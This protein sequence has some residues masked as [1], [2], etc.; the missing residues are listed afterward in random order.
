MLCSPD[1]IFQSY[2]QQ[3]L[4]SQL[5]ISCIYK[6]P[7]HVP[8][9]DGFDSEENDDESIYQYDYDGNSYQY[10]EHEY[11][12]NSEESEP[13]SDSTI[14]TMKETVP[15][16]SRMAPGTRSSSYKDEGYATYKFENCNA[17]KWYVKKGHGPNMFQLQGE[18]YHMM[19]SLKPPGSDSAKFCKCKL[20]SL[21]TYLTDKHLLGK[22]V[23]SMYTIEFQKRDLPHAHILLFMHNKS[24]FPT[25]DDIDKIISAE[26]PDKDS[27]AD[28]YDVVKDLTN[29][30]TCGAV[31][32]NSPCMENGI[33]TKQY[34]KTHVEVTT[35][36]KDG[37]PVYRRR[38]SDRFVEKT[39]SNVTTRM[40]Y[41]IT[42]SCL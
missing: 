10:G 34:P 11:D 21:M 18:N 16:L 41:H 42:S 35:V 23:A 36:N 9:A 7:M 6:A 3:Y 4:I 40:S 17:I 28:I 19:G 20:E 29:H 8:N 15:V 24:K 30:G 33:C 2:N 37:F 14:S 39:A 26:I 13:E 12:C 1:N 38:K 32:M 31:N 25:T 5:T 22:T 27:E